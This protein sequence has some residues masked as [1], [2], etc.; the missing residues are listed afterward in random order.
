MCICIHS[1]LR[2]GL[3]W[4]YPLRHQPWSRPGPVLFPKQD[5]IGDADD[6]GKA[7]ALESPAGREANATSFLQFDVP[8]GAMDIWPFIVSFP[9]KSG[10]FHSFWNYQR[11]KCTQHSQLLLTFYSK[12]TAIRQI[13][14]VSQALQWIMFIDND[15]NRTHVLT[16]ELTIILCMM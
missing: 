9:S 6:S 13:Y 16:I 4:S 7:L 10:D 5:F 3:W 8:S 11:V 12:P 14:S 2:E 1:N 15:H